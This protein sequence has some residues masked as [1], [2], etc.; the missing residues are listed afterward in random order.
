LRDRQVAFW[1]MSHSSDA[2]FH[3]DGEIVINEE[4]THLPVLG[5][6]APFK[7]QQFVNNALIRAKT[8]RVTEKTGD[9][10]KSQP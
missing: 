5:F 10:A 9:G 3:V 7:A 4:D 1:S 8:N 6:C 2:S